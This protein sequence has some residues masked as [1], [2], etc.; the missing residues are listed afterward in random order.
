MSSPEPDPLVGTVVDG[1]YRV[2]ERLS[3]GGM[4]IVYRAQQVFLKRE[5]ALKRLHR[6]L[7]GH[8]EAVARFEREAQAAAQIDHPNV[9]QVLD[10]GVGEDGAFFIA[11]E[12]LSGTPLDRR[13]AEAAPLPLAE[14]V[15]IGCQVCDALDHAHALGIV[16]RD[17]KPENVMLVPRRAGSGVAA[18]IMDFGIAKVAQEAGG[19]KLTQ[20]GMVFGTP[21]YM[22]PEQAAGEP[23][24]ARADVYAMGVILF[25][26]ATGR[27]PFEAPTLSAVLTKQLTEQAPPLEKA[28]PPSPRQTPAP[29]PGSP[30]GCSRGGGWSPPSAR[31]A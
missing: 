7:T 6:E 22:A 23:V 16:H 13:I 2:L 21:A 27:C 19:S 12:L 24:D 5:V 14:I 1:R 17:L 4:G 15:D 28:A 30:R 31:P 26:M 8:G 3:E 10:C 11:M 25:Q 18:K 20:A 29:P 9:C